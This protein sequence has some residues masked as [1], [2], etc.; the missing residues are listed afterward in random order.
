MKFTCNVYSLL[1]VLKELL[2]DNFAPFSTII[3]SRTLACQLVFIALCIIFTQS[4]TCWSWNYSIR[5]WECKQR[6]VI[7]SFS[8]CCQIVFRL[9]TW[10]ICCSE[11]YKM[12]NITRSIWIKV[13]NKRV[14]HVER[15]LH[16]RGIRQKFTYTKKNF[17][18]VFAWLTNNLYTNLLYAHSC[19]SLYCIYLLFSHNL[20]VNENIVFHHSHYILRGLLLLLIWGSRRLWWILADHN[21]NLKDT[22]QDE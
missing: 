22:V 18:S 11:G 6:F 4:I 9:R 3:R 15:W 20:L 10:N 12:L 7:F 13:A 5:N 2:L 14:C 19:S 17:L 21:L 1:G 8:E 16:V